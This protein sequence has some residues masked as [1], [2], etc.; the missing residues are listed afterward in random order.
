M[1]KGV[2]QRSAEHKL[3]LSEASKERFH[4]TKRICVDCWDPLPEH[5]SKRCVP[6]R[7]QKKKAV[8]RKSVQKNY[9]KNRKKRLAEIKE[10]DRRHKERRSQ[11]AKLRY[12]KKVL[13]QIHA[14]QTQLSKMPP[15]IPVRNANEIPAPNLLQP[16]VFTS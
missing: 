5:A 7:Q 10:Y 2:Y 16:K 8:V 13:A 4:S 1:P 11:L 12:R 14:T 9:H 6:C 15:G 3:K